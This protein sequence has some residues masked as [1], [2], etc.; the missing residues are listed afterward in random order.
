[1]AD[2]SMLVNKVSQELNS[3]LGTQNHDLHLYSL[4]FLYTQTL[5]LA[6][7]WEELGIAGLC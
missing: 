2:V 6:V 4:T 5:S 1:M 7:L 3:G